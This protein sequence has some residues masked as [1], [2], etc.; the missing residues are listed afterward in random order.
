MLKAVFPVTFVAS[1]LVSILVAPPI[2]AQQVAATQDVSGDSTEIPSEVP[3]I[4]QL[5]NYSGYLVVDE[6]GNLVELGNYCQRQVAR[7]TPQIS[8]FW[9][10]FEA[11]ANLRAIEVANQLGREEVVAYG[12]TICP[13]LEQGGSVQELRQIQSDGELPSDFEAAVMVAAI[14]TYCPTY[15][16]EI[17]R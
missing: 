13:F 4:C 7:S 8:R 15:Q 3:G 9:Q 11:T 12:T 6:T 2:Y 1:F 5:H 16:S 10:A 14:N 17:G